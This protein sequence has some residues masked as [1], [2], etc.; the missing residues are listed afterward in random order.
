MTLDEAFAA[1]ESRAG[2]DLTWFAEQWFQRSGVPAWR[3]EWEQAADTL[4]VEVIQREPHY[5]ATV[6]IE[7]QGRDCPEAPL[8]VTLEE[9]VS[10]FAWTMPCEVTE[11]LVDPHFHVLH[12]ETTP[13]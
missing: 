3:V 13:R 9:R 11:V 2:R 12:E 5:R 6:D 10:T 7:V 1:L 8:E 4:R